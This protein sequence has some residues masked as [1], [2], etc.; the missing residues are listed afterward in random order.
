[1]INATKKHKDGLTLSP[2]PHFT[3]ICIDNVNGFLSTD[4]L[5][6]LVTVTDI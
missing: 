1:M 6:N 3:D 4:V 2:E 5:V